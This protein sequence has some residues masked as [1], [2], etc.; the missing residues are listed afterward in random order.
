MKFRN[1]KSLIFVPL[2]L[3]AASVTGYSQLSITNSN[4]IVETFDAATP[5]VPTNWTT[6]LPGAGATLTYGTPGANVGTTGN[7]FYLLKPTASE[8][9]TAFGGKVATTDAGK[10]L[11]LFAQNNTG[12]AIAGFDLSWTYLQYDAGNRPSTLS[13]SYSLDN[14]SYITLGITVDSGALTYTA[15]E[16]TGLNSGSGSF[17]YTTS[18]L[19]SN[20]V[21]H[22]DLADDLANGADI[23]FRFTWAGTTT[24]GG[25]NAHLGIDNFSLAAV[26]EPSSFAL[27]IGSALMLRVVR[28]KRAS[29]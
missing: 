24:G 12:G 10:N 13:F 3:L 14:V 8:T 15:T 16:L 2:V 4:P 21:I 29:A 27:L 25:N 28:R 20:T 17:I 7:T 18:I 23:Y 11:T 9:D 1:P 19:S 26:P 22:I 5:T 6:D